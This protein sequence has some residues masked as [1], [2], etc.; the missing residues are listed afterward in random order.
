MVTHPTILHIVR[1]LQ[2]A[3]LIPGRIHSI[4]TSA[5][6]SGIMVANVHIDPE[7]SRVEQQNMFRAP[8]QAILPPAQ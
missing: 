7:L 1:S 4:R 3:F 8:R 2:H 5:G 6:D